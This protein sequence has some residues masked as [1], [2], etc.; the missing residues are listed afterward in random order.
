[1]QGRVV[2]SGLG[3]A[4]GPEVA[5]GVEL[6]LMVKNWLEPFFSSTRLLLLRAPLRSASATAATECG[7]CLG[8]QGRKWLKNARAQERRAGGRAVV[9]PG[10]LV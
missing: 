4:G 2:G 5:V 1:M 9:A 3:A 8:V 7:Q 10:G 6:C